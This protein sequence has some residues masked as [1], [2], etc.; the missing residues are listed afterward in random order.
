M[1]NMK[2]VKKKED[3][4]RE[5]S[6]NNDFFILK[7]AIDNRPRKSSRFAYIENVS[8]LKTDLDERPNSIALFYPSWT[9]GFQ[10]FYYL[11]NYNYLVL[12]IFIINGVKYVDSAYI[13]HFDLKSR[14]E[15]KIIKFDMLKVKIINNLKYFL[16]YCRF[17]S[18]IY[19]K[20]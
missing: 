9:V 6:L 15:V 5:T 17:I 19:S 20:K 3:I 18:K 13:C 14:Y 12:E 16:K 11:N 1:I 2:L 10:K 4:L 7:S 8:D